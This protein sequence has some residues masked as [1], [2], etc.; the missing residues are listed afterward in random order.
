M[1]LGTLHKKPYFLFPNVLKIWSFQKKRTGI[2][3]FLYYQEGRYFFFPKMWSYSL[4][5]KGKMI[6]LKKNT[7]KYGAFFKCFEKTVFAKIP[8][9][10]MFFFVI[11]G[12]M[13]FLFSLDGKWK[14][15][16]IKKN[17]EIWYFLYICICCKCD[18][19]L[20]PKK[21]KIILSRKNT[22]KGDISRITEKAD[23]HPRKHG[24]S[25][26]PCWLIF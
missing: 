10:N 25:E 11:S 19:V 14:M 1:F 23:N 21:P 5:A 26:I 15:I 6:F 20:L 22:V 18:I 12:K 13:V 3:S 4:H 17:M 24:I 9:L 8:P 16:F 2:W 7:W